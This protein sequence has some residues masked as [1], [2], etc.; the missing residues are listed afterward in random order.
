LKAGEILIGET[1]A[2]TGFLSTSKAVK[3]AR[4]EGSVMVAESGHDISSDVGQSV[5]DGTRPQMHLSKGVQVGVL[6]Q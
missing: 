5:I 6:P 1:G 3:P 4:E 2:D